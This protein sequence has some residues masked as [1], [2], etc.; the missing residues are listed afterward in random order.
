[1]IPITIDPCEHTPWLER[2]V[3]SEVDSKM[4]YVLPPKTIWLRPKDPAIS[5]FLLAVSLS[6]FSKVLARLKLAPKKQNSGR[7][8]NSIYR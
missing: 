8:P 3:S 5:A 4:P 7:A 1:M 2:R 6:I